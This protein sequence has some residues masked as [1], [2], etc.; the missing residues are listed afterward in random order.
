MDRKGP[1]MPDNVTTTGTD[2]RRPVNPEEVYLALGP[3]TIVERK[4]AVR[5]A[6][7][8]LVMLG[9]MVWG[10]WAQ[11][12]EMQERNQIERAKGD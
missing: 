2:D 1:A 5:C 10:V 6:F 8:A 4:A 12:W 11:V 3:F 9:L 7:L